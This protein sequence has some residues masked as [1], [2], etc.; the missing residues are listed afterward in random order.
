MQHNIASGPGAVSIYLVLKSGAVP[1]TSTA[2]APRAV[3]G[4]ARPAPATNSDHL[5]ELLDELSGI[6]NRYRRYIRK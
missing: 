4:G 3:L 2:T 5:R 6:N 1:K